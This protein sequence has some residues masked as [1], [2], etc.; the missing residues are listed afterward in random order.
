[1]SVTSY[2]HVLQHVFVVDPSLLEVRSSEHV[3]RLKRHRFGIIDCLADGA[4]IEA[5]LLGPSELL[6]V[7]LDEGSDVFSLP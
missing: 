2:Y 4:V 6:V 3:D 7:V 5:L 1:M